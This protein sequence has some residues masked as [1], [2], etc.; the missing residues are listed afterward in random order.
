MN[1]I[2]R[3]KQKETE[4]LQILNWQSEICTN[5]KTSKDGNKSSSQKFTVFDA[6][7]STQYLKR[8]RMCQRKTKQQRSNRFKT[9]PTCSINVK[10][11]I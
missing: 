1:S 5:F 10:S 6:K 11:Q 7:K 3:K 9:L 8:E 4:Q 2:S